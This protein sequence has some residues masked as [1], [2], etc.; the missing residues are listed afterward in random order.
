MTTNETPELPPC[1]NPECGRGDLEVAA[2]L[3]RKLVAVMHEIASCPIA[4]PDGVQLEMAAAVVAMKIAEKRM[5]RA[6]ELIPIPQPAE[7]ERSDAR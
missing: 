2:S 6:V 7:P 3:R 1:P 4:Y 5:R